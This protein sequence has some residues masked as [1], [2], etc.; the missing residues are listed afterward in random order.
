[1]CT[2]TYTHR[3]RHTERDRD[4]QRDRERG[5][6]EGCMLACTKKKHACTQR[7]KKSRYL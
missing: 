4:R 1:M 7:H 6:R 3:D 5:E 2:H